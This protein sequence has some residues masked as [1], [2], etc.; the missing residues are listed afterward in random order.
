MFDQFNRRIN[1]LRIS[2]TD[3]CNLRC[4]YCMPEDGI[5]QIPHNQILTFEEI[6]EITKLA[7][8]NGFEKVRITG[9]EPLV[10][11]G[12]VDLVKMIASID[13]I[14]DFGMTTNGVLLKPFAKPLFD[15]GLKRI[16]VSLDTLDPGKYK[17]TTRIGNLSDVLEG[18]E[19]AKRVGFKPIKL[20]CV[21]EQSSAEPDA[22]AVKS[23]ADENGFIARFIPKMNLD[24]GI[25]GVVE[26]GEGGNCATCNR[27]RLTANGV[28]KP[29]L[30]SESGYNVR[31]LGIEKAIEMAIKNKPACGVAN[32]T[33]EFYNIGG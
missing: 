12:I 11:K 33:G 14:M 20:N 24:D 27:L 7:V 1:Y 28:I 23:Y 22:Q 25:F 32:R 16:N 6:V 2:V 9:G 4:V 10:R 17:A 19:E 5:E 18:L 15:A 26:G 29:C 8:K 30:F 31:D 21:V 13:G 3:R